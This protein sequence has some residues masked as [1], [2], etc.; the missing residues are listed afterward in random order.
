MSPRRKTLVELF[1]LTVVLLIVLAG[2][3]KHI[4]AYEATNDTGDAIWAVGT[5]IAAIINYERIQKH[6]RDL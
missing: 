3:Y 2:C 5:G 6:W 4:L 1:L